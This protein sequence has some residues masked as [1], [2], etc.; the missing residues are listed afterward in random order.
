VGPNVI[1]NEYLDNL[2]ESGYELL[3]NKFTRTP[4]DI[5]HSCFDHIFVKNNN[6]INGKIEVGVLQAILQTITQKSKYS[7]Q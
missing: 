2:S 3:I 6:N 1:N 7:N 5:K 4:L